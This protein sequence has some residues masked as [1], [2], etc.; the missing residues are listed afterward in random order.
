MN[1]VVDV[2]DGGMG[3]RGVGRC[4]EMSGV[5]TTTATPEEIM[6]KMKKVVEITGDEE[7]EESG[8]SFV[9]SEWV[10]RLQ[11]GWLRCAN[12]YCQLIM[13]RQCFAP[14]AHIVTICV[15]LV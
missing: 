9:K 11:L 7:R 4:S 5:D 3:K 12:L 6:L 13:V 15:L 2:I 8:W 10:E 1:R 14:F